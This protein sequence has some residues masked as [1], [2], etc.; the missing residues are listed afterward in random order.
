VAALYSTTGYASYLTGEWKGDRFAFRSKS[1]GNFA[2]VLD[3]VKPEVELI[4]ALPGKISKNTV[5]HFRVGDDKT[6]VAEYGAY[7]N[8]EWV[9][10]EYEPKNRRLSVIFKEANLSEGSGEFKLEVKDAVGNTR[11]VEYS[12]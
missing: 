12:F 9:L 6:G 4:S 10:T 8:E 5:L 7:L 2:L 11:T 1:F 3:S